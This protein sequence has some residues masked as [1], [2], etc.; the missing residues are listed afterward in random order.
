MSRYNLLKRGSMRRIRNSH[1]GHRSAADPGDVKSIA[2]ILRAVYESISGPAG[3]PRDWA[4][5]RSL[6]LPDGR[7]ILAIRKRG[8][9][10]RARFLTV[11]DY[12][13]RT[14]PFFAKEDFWEVESGR[15]SRV[16]GN[17]AHVFSAYESRRTRRGKPFARGVNSIQ[18]FRDTRRW[19]IATV[20]WNTQRG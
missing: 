5:F 16:I 7:L 8:E 15:R 18:L 6:F 4:G 17:M 10:P 19:C 20:M 13:R 14:D 9:K 3:Q 12:V 11:D 2:S 1:P